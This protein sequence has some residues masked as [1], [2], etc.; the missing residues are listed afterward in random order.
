MEPSYRS[1]Q[2][3]YQP[4]GLEG[5][6]NSERVSIRSDISR[7]HE[8]ASNSKQAAV[9]TEPPLIN[10][11]QC[12]LCDQFAAGS[13]SAA[14]ES[15]VLLKW[16]YGD[17][18]FPS[19]SVLTLHL[20][21]NLTLT[22]TGPVIKD[23]VF[24]KLPLTQ[25][26]QKKKI[27]F[28]WIPSHLVTEKIL[29]TALANNRVQSWHNIPGKFQ[30]L[31]TASQFLLLNPGIIT[32][33]PAEWKN[34]PLISGHYSELTRSDH[35]FLSDIPEQHREHL[36]K[37]VLP[38]TPGAAIYLN[39]TSPDYEQLVVSALNK[40][41][42]L[43]K[44]FLLLDSTA[45]FTESLVDAALVTSQ[46][47]GAGLKTV[48]EQYIT[49]ERC[50]R[51]ILAGHFRD[52]MFNVYKTD[53]AFNRFKHLVCA[54]N[55]LLKAVKEHHWQH[56]YSLALLPEKELTEDLCA[57]HLDCFPAAIDAIPVSLLATHRQWCLEAVV[58][59]PWVLDKNHIPSSHLDDAFYNYV[60]KKNPSS[61]RYFPGKLLDREPQLIFQAIENNASL[62][63]LPKE[64]RSSLELCRMAVSHDPYEI[65]NVPSELLADMPLAPRIAFRPKD[66]SGSVKKI[67][68]D[69]CDTG[70][71]VP[72]FI[73]ELQP[74][75][76]LTPLSPLIS[77]VSSAM[78]NKLAIQLISNSP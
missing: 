53:R 39:N 5:Q 31:S 49:A 47:T 70:S 8:I 22:R 67:L 54:D 14:T 65:K 75:E 50:C 29:Y 60:L 6:P 7:S 38:D 63:V 56:P 9:K 52:I 58:C 45:K 11:R 78:L 17:K 19:P 32:G 24:N 40:R 33:L 61:I 44:E 15:T 35:R 68:I 23:D 42:D 3:K 18:R 25:L 12:Q 76:L 55:D 1:Q 73:P 4:C 16:L 51:A 62:F 41:G 77:G 66:L 46:R 69:T 48:P 28:N 43:L 30:N 21:C 72:H 2:H 10:Q 59:S 36:C 34:H 71:L 13:Y 37:Q 27:K 20:L 26:L 64:R 57:R 74:S